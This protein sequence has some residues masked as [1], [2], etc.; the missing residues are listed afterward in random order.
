M[1]AFLCVHTLY[2]DYIIAKPNHSLKKNSIRKWKPLWDSLQ[3]ARNKPKP[4]ADAF[5]VEIRATCAE[6]SKDR[7]WKAGRERGCDA[8]TIG[9]LWECQNSK[10]TT[11][12]HCHS[13]FLNALL[14][15]RKLHLQCSLR[16]SL[17]VTAWCHFRKHW[18]HLLIVSS[19]AL[20][21]SSRHLSLI[22]TFISHLDISLKISLRVSYANYH[23]FTLMCK[24]LMISNKTQ[25]RSNT[26]KCLNE[27]VNIEEEH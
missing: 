19:R 5:D 1:C 14:L 17:S 7:T 9:C 12:S 22:K 11:F 13:T 16:R 3:R 8:L 15:Q 23:T 6:R 4:Q 25:R 10:H 26:M 21:P 18:N 24:W 27:R 2:T 20:F